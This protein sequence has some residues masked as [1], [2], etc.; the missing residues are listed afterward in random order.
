MKNKNSKT[1]WPLDIKTSITN[2]KG[3][4]NIDWHLEEKQ[5]QLTKE[6]QSDKRAQE[7]KETYYML[8]GQASLM[9]AGKEKNE[10]IGNATDILVEHI[11][12]T[13]HV[14]T[15]I[16]PT[17][18]QMWIYEN[19]IYTRN[20]TP[21]IEE[22]LR[23]HIFQKLYKKTT[24]AS[25]IERIK[26][27][28]LID[29]KDF[30][31]QDPHLIC[32]KNG[33]LDTKNLNLVE[34]SPQFVF[35]SKINANYDEKASAQEILNIF[36]E[37]LPQ[38]DKLKTLQELFGYCLYRKYP[39]H[40]IFFFIG[41]GRNG[42]GTTLTILQNMLG[43][44]NTSNITIQEL[45]KG[46][47][48]VANLYGKLSNI[49]GDIAAIKIHSTAKIKGLS[50]GDELSAEMK[51]IQ[52]PIMFENY[53]KMV[54]SCNKIP[55]WDDDSLAWYSRTIPIKFE[56]QYLR[57]KELKNLEDSDEKKVSKRQIQGLA[58][59]LS[60]DSN[61]SGIL[62]WALEGLARLLKNGDF[63]DK[64]ILSERKEIL[65]LSSNPFKVFVRKELKESFGCEISK[66]SL[67]KEFLR[68]CKK[69]KTYPT[70]NDKEIKQI[71]NNTFP[72]KER[73]IHVLDGRE[74]V[75][76][77]FDFVKNEEQ[78]SFDSGQISL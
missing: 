24:V 25:I 62:N 68:W 2:Y 39:I 75:W 37:Y 35:L 77:G 71:L 14:K 13:F 48:A 11:I 46:R 60:T 34:H 15:I 16:S 70:E 9:G 55:K 41:S 8:L 44:E 52:D 6:E 20:A 4:Q 61:I 29:R 1:K 54:F 64:S 63:S 32:V 73:S 47:F 26:L 18:P 12:Q 67:R 74:R 65:E 53:A 76:V 43:K 10:I 57:E 49:G 5:P 45:E 38:E 17:E 59:K 30:E 23:K 72:L 78:R 22:Y 40:N 7:I 3:E 51:N 21:R 58:D 69:M 31:E 27:D 56:R 28:T 19:G 50:G 42:K 66:D 33:I 36:K